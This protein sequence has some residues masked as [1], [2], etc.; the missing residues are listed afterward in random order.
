M[1]MLSLAC[2]GYTRRAWDTTKLGKLVSEAPAVPSL[3]ELH[4]ADT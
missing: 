3:L 1:E 2:Q 4:G